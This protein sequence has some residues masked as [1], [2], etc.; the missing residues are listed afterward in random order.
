MR[1]VGCDLRVTRRRLNRVWVAHEYSDS[2]ATLSGLF[3][4]VYTSRSVTRVTPRS[5]RGS[6]GGRTV[7]DRGGELA[8]AVV[9]A[10]HGFLVLRQ[11]RGQSRG[12]GHHRQLG[13]HGGD[14]E[15]EHVLTAEHGLEGG[16]D[17]V[18]AV[19]GCAGTVAT[20]PRRNHH[21]WT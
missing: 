20:A 6:G 15:A 4:D 21:R 13:D 5:I 1:L 16:H 19:L 12:V 7:G 14:V 2:V 8:G 3:E 9:S 11:Q 18:Q 17:V 10:G